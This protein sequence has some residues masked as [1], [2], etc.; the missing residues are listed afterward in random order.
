MPTKRDV[1]Y[2]V[3]LKY[4]I[5]KL[6]SSNWSIFSYVLEKRLG[7]VR[8]GVLSGECPICGSRFKGVAGVRKHLARSDCR[9]V[10]KILVNGVI[11]EYERIRYRRI[12]SGK[13]Y[14]YEVQLPSGEVVKVRGLH[15][16]VP[17]LETLKDESV[18]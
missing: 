17:Y 13:H 11:E 7:W 12:K 16:L 9:S 2:Y 14:F 4:A 18:F 3:A 5:G 8:R 15:E 10:L 6:K 1:F